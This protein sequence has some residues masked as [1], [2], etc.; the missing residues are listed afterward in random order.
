MAFHPQSFDPG[1]QRRHDMSDESSVSD[2]VIQAIIKMADLKR[3]L[4]ESYPR[5]RLKGFCPK[6]GAVVWVRKTSV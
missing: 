2:Q 3:V 6:F 5:M 1:S 4:N